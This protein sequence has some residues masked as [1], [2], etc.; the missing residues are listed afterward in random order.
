MKE[1]LLKIIQLQVR[2]KTVHKNQLLTNKT[3]AL[4]LQTA[5]IKKM[6]PV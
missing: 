6:A 2:K 1:R 4:K 3:T 5:D